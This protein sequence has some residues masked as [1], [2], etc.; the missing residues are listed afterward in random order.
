M[1]IRIYHLTRRNLIPILMIIGVVHILLL[2]QKND[3]NYLH[4]ENVTHF[5]S[6]TTSV[7]TNF[8]LFPEDLPN[9]SSISDRVIEQLNFRPTLLQRNISV[10][11]AQTNW[12]RVDGKR[13][14]FL[15]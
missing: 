7:M 1:A 5:E 14:K 3:T 6:H 11:I 2:L 12:E 15:Q 10:F 9:T 4:I 13:C 8:G